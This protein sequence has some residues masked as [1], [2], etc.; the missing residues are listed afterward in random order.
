MIGPERSTVFSQTVVTALSLPSAH[1]SSLPSD[2]RYRRTDW[3][4][5]SSPLHGRRFLG[6]SSNGLGRENTSHASRSAERPEAMVL[7]EVVLSTM[8]LVSS[9]EPRAGGGGAACRRSWSALTGSTS[10]GSMRTI[11]MGS[12]SWLWRPGPVRGPVG[13]SEVALLHER[14][15]SLMSLSAAVGDPGGRA[16]G[17]QPRRGCGRRAPGGPRRGG[18]SGPPAAARRRR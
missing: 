14:R 15:A 1:T 11:V 17:D 13:T 6:R 12:C 9:P 7:T 2:R 3:I 10:T 5:R 16:R 18:H 4:R 8:A